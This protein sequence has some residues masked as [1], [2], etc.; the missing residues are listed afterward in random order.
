MVS[1]IGDNR[2]GLFEISVRPQ[3]FGGEK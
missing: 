2:N 1:R 3:L